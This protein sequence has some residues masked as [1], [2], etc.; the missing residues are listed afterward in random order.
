MSEAYLSLQKQYQLLVISVISVSTTESTISLCCHH[1]LLSTGSCDCKGWELH[2]HVFSWS[3]PNN[4]QTHSLHKLY[5]T[6]CRVLETLLPWL[7]IYWPIFYQICFWKQET[8]NRYSINT[9][10]K[11]IELTTE[12][13]RRGKD[14]TNALAI[15][16]HFNRI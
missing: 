8:E 15:K 9:S 4:F 5:E 6:T 7:K 12:R 13:K 10:R 2:V 11:W 1:T 14:S 3:A 16:I